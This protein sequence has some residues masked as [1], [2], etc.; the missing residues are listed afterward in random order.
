M[1]KMTAA[2]IEPPKKKRGRPRKAAAPKEDASE[3]SL[4][5]C[6]SDVTVPKSCSVGI[7]KDIR[8]EPESA[9][10]PLEFLLMKRIV[11]QT[12]TAGEWIVGLGEEDRRC[13]LRQTEENPEPRDDDLGP[14]PRD[15]GMVGL[16]PEAD[17]VFPH[18]CG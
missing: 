6:G 17:R 7:R 18:P 11:G 2:G 9:K 8:G 1:T 13:A 14:T 12:I 10:D 15:A 3:K 5:S 4:E 16:G